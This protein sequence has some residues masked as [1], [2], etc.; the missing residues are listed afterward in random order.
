MDAHGASTAG[1]AAEHQ[2]CIRGRCYLKRV[3]DFGYRNLAFWGDRGIGSTTTY[4]REGDYC[5]CIVA[6]GW[7]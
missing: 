6:W 2:V 1:M 3:A 5:Y 4:N 7:I